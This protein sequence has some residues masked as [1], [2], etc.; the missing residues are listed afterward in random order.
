MRRID[1]TSVGDLKAPP[2]TQSTNNVS[3]QR[4]ENLRIKPRG[5]NVNYLRLQELLRTSHDNQYPQTKNLEMQPNWLKQ[6]KSNIN[7]CIFRHPQ[8][9]EQF[10]IFKIL[11]S[12]PM[13]A[14]A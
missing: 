12:H 5:H 10:I 14:N 8:I 13:E 7:P 3:R 9:V 2:E 11:R 4:N 6:H 1:Y